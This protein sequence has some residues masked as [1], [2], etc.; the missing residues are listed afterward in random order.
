MELG[1]D[2]TEAD[3]Q[4]KCLT[5]SFFTDLL[6]IRLGQQMDGYSVF[7]NR[8]N[9]LNSGEKETTFPI[10]YTLP[11]LSAQLHYSARKLSEAIRQTA[12]KES[13]SLDMRQEV[14]ISSIIYRDIIEVLISL[15]NRPPTP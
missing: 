15:S 12:K 10:S 13:H 2:H 6:D 3:P 5:I 11:Y 7:N 4:S 8:S 9:Y 1:L 14:K